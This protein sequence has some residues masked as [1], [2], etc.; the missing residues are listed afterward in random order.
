MIFGFYGDSKSGK[1]RLV[2]EL[3]DRLNDENYK[4][5]VIKH[6]SYDKFDLDTKGKDTDLFFSGASNAVIGSAK[7]QTI[8]F[9]KGSEN[10]EKL[11]SFLKYF[12]NFDFVLVEGF[13]NVEW[14]K[15]I[16]IGDIK[17]A[18]N[19]VFKFDN[20]IDKVLEYLKI[21][22]RIEKIYDALPQFDCGKCGYKDCLEMA[23]TIYEKKNRFKNC[24]Y[25][26]P[27]KKISLKVDE[28]DV[29]LGKFAQKILF[30]TVKGLVK[31]LKNSGKAEH[32]E[33]EIKKL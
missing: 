17:D 21:N 32:I 4:V 5:A 31:S 14:L 10:L 2:L 1:T 28:R 24:E 26:N 13:K 6:T 25:W 12:Y 20:N 23:K 9:I 27:D 7:N 19:T 3:A 16:K 29:Y 33:I 22:R 30:N 11:Y 15:K 8:I 18:N